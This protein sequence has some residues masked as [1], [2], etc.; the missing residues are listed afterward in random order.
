MCF[1]SLVEL[2]VPTV[3]DALATRQPDVPALVQGDCA[4]TY[5]GLSERTDRLA[6]VLL[7]HGVGRRA[8]HEDVAPWESP[9]EHVALY[10]LNCPEY[11]EGMV[12]AWKAGA[13][14]M[15]VNYRYV[16]DELA[17][18]L[19]DGRAAAVLVHRRFLPTLAEVRDR[20]S[21]PPR[22]VLVV[23]DD[24]GHPL[25]PWATP[26]D[27]A[28]AAATG[29]IPSGVRAAWSG[30][31][32]YLCY[33]GGTTGS[34]KGTLWRQDDLL[35]AALGVGRR[36]GTPFASLDEV[37]DAANPRLCTLPAPPMMHGAAHWNALSCL[38][39]GGTV[40]MQRVVDRFDPDDVLDAVEA[41][42]A[43]SLLLVGD[44]MARPL[45]GALGR[46][47]SPPPSLRHVVSG[48]AVLSP[49]V[50]DQFL[51]AVPGLRVIDVLGS[52]ESGRQGVASADAASPAPSGFRPASSSVVLSEDLSHRLTAGDGAIGWLAQTG[53]V[54]L[55]YLGH[56]ERTAA[57]FPV[58]DGL[59]H[60]VP[61]D[62]ARLLADGTVELLGR[63]SACIN[64]GGEKVF[65]EEV[66]VALTS[67]PEVV[68]AVVCG[69]PSERFGQEVVAVVQ[70]ADGATATDKDL[71]THAGAELARYKLPRAFVR[72]P[73][74]VRSP[75]GKAD[76]RWAAAQVASP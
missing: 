20:L 37:L 3:L 52:T 71:R 67:H 23:D 33:T 54:P 9:H 17:Y 45:L 34:P 73:L 60:A 26:M 36:D 21:N 38:L 51:A 19:E 69:R 29:E 35:R 13:T 5:A 18:L 16:A 59:R 49:S 32:R 28:L 47:E 15:N 65:A 46:R 25:P 22:L 57:T 39:A 10:L 62:R 40:A 14:S 30:D 27:G 41:H 44:P 1:H 24:T 6:T 8:R 31:D 11:L 48:G 53:R 7:A 74:V 56:P 42:A 55:G 61:G 70:M 43:S 50:R 58:V 75:S 64:T 2:H 76:Y 12:A 63:D 4:L 68:D 72:V 66:E